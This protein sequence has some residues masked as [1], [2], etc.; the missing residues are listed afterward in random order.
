VNWPQEQ[1]GEQDGEQDVA[2][3]AEGERKSKQK[4]PNLDELA[5]KKKMWANDRRSERPTKGPKCEL[6]LS[7]I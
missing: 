4:W 6:Q 2:A 1:D 7:A 5:G 3:V